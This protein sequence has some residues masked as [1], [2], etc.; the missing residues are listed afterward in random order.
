MSSPASSSIR[1]NSAWISGVIS[2]SI[3]PS[4]YQPYCVLVSTVPTPN[5]EAMMRPVATTA[6]PTWPMVTPD[7]MPPTAV[8]NASS[9][10]RNSLVPAKTLSVMT[11]ATAKATSTAKPPSSTPIP[12][13]ST[14]SS[15]SLEIRRATPRLSAVTPPTTTSAVRMPPTQLAWASLSVPSSASCNRSPAT[16]QL[17]TMASAV[18]SSATTAPK[19]T[20]L[21]LAAA[22]VFASGS[23]CRGE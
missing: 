9:A 17:K 20:R 10:S 12:T 8:M 22:R 13:W 18:A 19:A 23:G 4:K 3:R 11:R 14:V 21:D 6:A 1:S 7:N 2:E 5:A 16:S 15:S